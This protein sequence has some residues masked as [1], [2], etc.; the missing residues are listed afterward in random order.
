MREYGYFS[1]LFTT[2]W[3]QAGLTHFNNYFH[4]QLISVLIYLFVWINVVE[5]QKMLSN[6]KKYSKNQTCSDIEVTVK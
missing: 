1:E 4:Y 3:V 2:R 6:V 5:C